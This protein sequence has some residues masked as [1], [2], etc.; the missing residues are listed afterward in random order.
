MCG[1][2]APRGSVSRGSR[3]VVDADDD[4]G[5]AAAAAAVDGTL[6]GDVCGEAGGDV[7]VQREVRPLPPSGDPK[8]ELCS[9]LPPPS[10]TTSG[11]KE[12]DD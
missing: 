2:S 6:V 11:W 7:E 8:E 12:V 3:I 1:G 10:T 5:P 9:P 4:A